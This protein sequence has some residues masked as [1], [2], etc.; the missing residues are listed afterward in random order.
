[1]DIYRRISLIRTEGEADDLT[2]EL[3]D[4]FGDPPRGVNSLIHVALLRG[5]AGKAGISDIS[6]KG[7]AL[8]FIV[9]D[10]DMARVSWLYAK[11]EYKGKLRVEAGSK[12]CISL[13]LPP[14]AR[15]IEE[16][17][18]FV[19]DWLKSAEAPLGGLR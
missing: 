3:I 4:R 19:G 18:R 9:E 5:E 2:D 7:G 11:P 15:S 16:A 13:R 8:R 12:P 1:M 6:Q 17:R 14:K 10:F